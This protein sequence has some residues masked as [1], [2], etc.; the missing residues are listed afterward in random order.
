MTE[1]QARHAV[2]VL[3]GMTGA[4]TTP[5]RDG[6]RW[7][8]SVSLGIGLHVTVESGPHGGLKVTFPDESRCLAQDVVRA[9]EHIQLAFSA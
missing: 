1:D 2:V 9:G 7:Y 5:H 4:D 8:V 6:G 3:Y